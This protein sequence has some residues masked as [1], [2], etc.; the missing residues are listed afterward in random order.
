MQLYLKLICDLFDSKQHLCR[1]RRRSKP[2]FRLLNLLDY[3]LLAKLLR[4]Q[5]ESII[6][7]KKP[8]KE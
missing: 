5:L 1:L 3:N 6:G 8:A 4:R 2:S 7:Q